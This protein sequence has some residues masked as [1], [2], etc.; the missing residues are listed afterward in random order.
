MENLGSLSAVI[1]SVVHPVLALNTKHQVVAINT[2]AAELLC[3]NEVSKG[4]I[5]FGQ[6]LGC[7]NAI[8]I[9]ECGTSIFCTR[10]R[11]SQVLDMIF[12]NRGVLK[13]GRAHV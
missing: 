6:L 10:C 2:Q 4:M 9:S 12:E 3:V 11:I 7:D 5:T 1:D 13:I 8:N